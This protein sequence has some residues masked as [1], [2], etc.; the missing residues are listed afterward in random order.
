MAGLIN[1]K[2][3]FLALADP[4][5]SIEG[6]SRLR[7]PLHLRRGHQCRS[8]VKITIAAAYAFLARYAGKCFQPIDVHLAANK[9]SR[10]A[11]L[12]LSFQPLDVV[13]PPSHSE[14]V[15]MMSCGAVAHIL[16]CL[17]LEF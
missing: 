1:V 10:I 4:K 16:H 9:D 17:D 6:N 15:T 13:S 7:L 11:A 2:S 12:V 8:L 14:C 3:L 5:H